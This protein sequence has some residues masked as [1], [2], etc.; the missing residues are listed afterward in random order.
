MPV[1]QKTDYLLM[2]EGLSVRTSMKPGDS[3]LQ[4]KTLMDTKKFMEYDVF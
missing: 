1:F 3:F 2:D 4:L